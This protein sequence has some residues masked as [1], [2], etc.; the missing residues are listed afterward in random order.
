MGNTGDSNGSIPTVQPIYLRKTF[1][2]QPRCAAENSIAFVSKV[3]LANVG[4]YGLSKRCMPVTRCT[5][6]TKKDMLLND[7]LPVIKVDPETF[8]VTA[9]GQ[10]MASEPA[11]QVALS[12]GTGIF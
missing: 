4:H 3:S 1:G 2:F 5:G 12:V 6:L 9:D 8:G 7:T 10:L 11:T